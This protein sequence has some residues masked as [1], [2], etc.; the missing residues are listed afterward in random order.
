MS[1]H[2]EITDL[3]ASQSPLLI[4]KE[5]YLQAIFHIINT[6]SVSKL[7][8]PDPSSFFFDDDIPT[9]EEQ[10]KK[11]LDKIRAAIKMSSASGVNLTTEYRS[12]EIPSLSVAYHRVFGTIL[13]DAV[14]SFSSK[15]FTRNLVAADSNDLISCH[16]V[17]INSGGGEAWYLDQVSLAMASC[18]KPIYVFIEKYCC[19][20]AYYIGCHGQKMVCLTQN[21]TIGCIGTMI[22]FWNLDPYLQNLGIQIIEEYAHQSDLK[23]KKY[24]DLK[25]GK[26]DQ[27]ITEELDPLAAQFITAV[28]TNRSALSSL[29]DDSPILR[30]ETY[31][32]SAAVANGLVD[33]ILTI[34]Q[35]VAEAYAMGK[36]YADRITTRKRIAQ[37]L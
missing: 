9:Y 25:E 22:S 19:S 8:K 10:N 29:Q 18:V 31:D 13:S 23:N 32:G 3:I 33:G 6:S 11:A 37:M 21:D 24:T 30:G 35:S 17:H 34:E 20:A 2:R 12:N 1:Y 4:T 36:E 16:F 15:D 27:F 14:Y 5:A 28:R 7:A 26:P